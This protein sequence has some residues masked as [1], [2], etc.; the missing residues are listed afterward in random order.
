M[1]RSSIIASAAL[2]GVLAIAQPPVAHSAEPDPVGL[3]GD[4]SG[5]WFDPAK[6][7]HG[8]MFEVL[9]SGRALIA[10]YTFD[11]E[12]RPLWLYGIGELGA[13]SVSAPMFSVEGGRFPPNFDPA[14]I[15]VMPWGEVTL[16]F[17]DCNTG[18]VT[19]EPTADGFAA[20]SMPLARITALQGTRCNLEE[21]YAEQRSF[22][23]ERG[24]G[25]FQPVFVDLP[26][27]GQDI[28]ELD[29][30][31][32]PL[33]EP[34]AA[35][36]GL[37]LTGHNRSDDLAMLIT[38]PLGGLLPDTAYRVELEVELASDVPQGC[39]G[40]GG[41]PGDSVYLKLGVA[42][43]EPKA[44][45]V[46]EGDVPTLRLNVDFGNQSVGGENG[47][48]VGTLAKSG[49][50]DDPAAH[51]WELKTLSTAGQ[52]IEARSDGQGRLWL[53][54]GTDSAFEG[55]TNV[56]FTALKVRLERQ[57]EQD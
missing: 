24:A 12:G 8:L 29:F 14:Q 56:Y 43:D 38:A 21:T 7:G 36:R 22:H 26:A 16:S 40:I 3:R 47:R 18:Q 19:W 31:Y 32:E 25:A 44:L 33:P 45:T 48:V 35:R 46:N 54:A 52:L 51:R 34:L 37:R 39:A 49:Q 15:E 50:C 9:D 11:G 17:T 53:L 42:T 55:L 1:L 10:W 28:Y 57:G 30:Q 41:S 27:Q 2:A 13:H 20:G 4:F 23:F 5:T 6:P